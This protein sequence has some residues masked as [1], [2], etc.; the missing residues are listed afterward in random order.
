MKWKE[1]CRTLPLT[2]SSLSRHHCNA[3]C[4]LFLANFFLSKMA[5]QRM[6]WMNASIEAAVRVRVVA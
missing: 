6:G 2:L 3:C 5:S 1:G 4:Q